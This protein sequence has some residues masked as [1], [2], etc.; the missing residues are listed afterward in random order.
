M[1]IAETVHNYFQ[2]ASEIAKFL[3][4]AAFAAEL[5]AATLA[6]H[7]L[8]GGTSLAY[9][10][11][12]LAI[13]FVAFFAIALHNLALWIEQFAHRCRRTALHSYALNQKIGPRLFDEIES[14]KPPFVKTFTKK[15]PATSLERYYQPMC[16][17][18]PSRLRELYA[19][20]AFYNWKLLSV[21]GSLAVV[22]GIALLTAGLVLTYALAVRP[23]EGSDSLQVRAIL[24]DGFYSIVLALLALRSLQKSL[25][26]FMSS[27][28]MKRLNNALLASPLPE[29]KDLQDLIL[30]YEAERA[31]T[32]LIPTLL[33]RLRRN[34][35]EKRWIALRGVLG[36][37]EQAPGGRAQP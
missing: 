20:S 34:Q 23:P 24:L 13:V 21:Y 9:G 4:R 15:L 8:V 14:Q 31:R 16:P 1:T 17:V 28:T 33:Y 12:P 10:W 26:A 6:V 3:H 32:P 7:G 27:A 11:R 2:G 18:G 5:A 37:P 25:I 36:C 22:A 29:A 35:L 30:D 19:H